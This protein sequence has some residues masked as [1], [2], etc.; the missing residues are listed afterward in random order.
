[1]RTIG[2]AAFLLA[3]MTQRAGAAPHWINVSTSHFEMYTPA[4]EHEAQVAMQTFE[5]V[6][7]FFGKKLSASL[8]VDSKVRIIAFNSE[9]EFKPYR[10]NE[11]TFAFYQRGQARDYIVMQDIQKVHSQAAIHEYTHLVIEHLGLQIPVWLNEGLAD[12]YSSLE[13]Y[14][15]DSAMVGRPLEGYAGLINQKWIDWDVLLNVDHNSPYYNEKDKMSVFYAQS[16]LLTH[17]LDL[18]PEYSPK[19]GQFLVA[20]S[21]GNSSKDAFQKVYGKSLQDLDKDVRMYVRQQTVRAAIVP[22]TL[23]KSDMD[24]DVAPLP[25]FE[26]ELALAEL[27]AS[28][29]SG[30]QEGRERLRGLEAGHGES[31]EL[32]EALGYAALQTRD[33]ADA[34]AEFLQAAQ[35]G[36]K[37]AKM[38][39]QLAALQ[40]R[41]RNPVADSIASLNAAVNLAPHDDE[42]RL[43][44][45]SLY[46]E[47]GKCGASVSMAA[48]LHK[49]KPDQAYQY[50]SMMAFCYGRLKQPKV[51]HELAE[52][53]MR[54]AKTDQERAQ[55]DRIL[56]WT[57]Q[58][59]EAPAGSQ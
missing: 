17:M 25:D 9:K 18:S 2:L 27:K 32:H 12:L 22:V 50:Y 44:L 26:R 38:Y 19:F 54:V 3:V 24:A 53:A 23:P 45:A 49:V 56:T 42:S 34:R 21:N 43:F 16:W 7:Y 13:P 30:V 52:K 11:G 14:K 39:Y 8:D 35:H 4:N 6:Y 15:K 57:A 48:G 40:R 51:A 41:L 55:A 37:N 5:Q 47:D 33:E 20:V 36:S 10:P 46:A 29:V 59:I 58:A 31:V 28:T 1:M